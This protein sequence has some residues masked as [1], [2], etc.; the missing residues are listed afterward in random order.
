MFDED[1][2]F[3]I[4]I[5]YAKATPEDIVI[6]IEAF[7]RG[8]DAAPLQSCRTVVSQYLGLGARAGRPSRRSAAGRISPDGFSAW[9]TD[10]T[11][12]HGPRDHPGRLSPGTR[13]L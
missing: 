5:E 2:Y 12:G 3:D 4:V 13:T 7:N 1:R 9:S 10:D 6:R 8:P 11:G